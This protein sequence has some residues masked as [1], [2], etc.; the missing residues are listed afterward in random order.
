VSTHATAS[1]EAQRPCADGEAGA[2]APR[3]SEQ[4]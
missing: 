3:N 4:G 2:W 1:D